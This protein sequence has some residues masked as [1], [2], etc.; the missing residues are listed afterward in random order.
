MTMDKKRVAVIYDTSYLLGDFQSIKSF[1]LSRRFSSLEKPGLLSSLASMIGKGKGKTG[2]EKTVPYESGSLFDVAQVVPHE[3]IDEV[4]KRMGAGEKENK[5]VAALRADGAI[6][7]R[8]SMDSVVGGK[9]QSELAAP[10][11]DAEL[12]QLMEKETDGK[13]LGYATRL[14]N[15]ATK[16]RYDLSIIATEDDDFLQ[17][18]A[19][20]GKQ[21]KAVIGVSIENLTHSRNLHDKLSELASLGRAMKI[22]MEN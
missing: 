1:I 2:A 16:E 14:V 13:I 4:G 5:A 7:V 17:R 19:E 11:L 12:E 20:L 8:L 15:P 10:Q 3:V 6:L 18:I 22:T 21:G 9:R